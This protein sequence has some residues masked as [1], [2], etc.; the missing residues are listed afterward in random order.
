[1]KIKRKGDYEY[2]KE[3]HQDASFPVVPKV[4]EKVLVENAD[5]RET[6]ENWPDMMDFMGRIKV[7]RSSKLLF[8]EKEIQNT[9]RYYVAK[10]G[11]ELIKMMPPETKKGKTEWRRFQVKS[12]WKVCVCNDIRDA[13]LPV[14]YEYYIDEVYKLT[15]GLR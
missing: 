2:K 5:I 8:D 12:G 7:P 9:T 1:M 6:V 14:D 3:W 15:L 13:I 11:G 4:V 10:S